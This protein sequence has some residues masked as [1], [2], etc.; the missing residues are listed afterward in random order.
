[1]FISI[2]KHDGDESMSMAIAPC[3]IVKERIALE[4]SKAG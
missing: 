3:I 2:L 4:I 1:M